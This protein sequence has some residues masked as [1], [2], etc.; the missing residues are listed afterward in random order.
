M[1]ASIAAF[2][3]AGPLVVRFQL[4]VALQS[5]AAVPIPG[6]RVFPARGKNS[7]VDV[8]WH[9]VPAFCAWCRENGVGAT[10]TAWPA[11]WPDPAMRVPWESIAETLEAR[12]EL[13]APF[14]RPWA[15]GYQ[16][17]AL[18]F[19]AN[20]PGAFL[21]HP[22]GSGK[23]WTAIAWALLSGGPL[24]VVTPA[25]TR[26]QYAAQIERFTTRKAFAC[27]PATEIRKRDKW[28]TLPEYLAWCVEKRQEPALV[29]GWETLVDWASALE[30]VLQ[31][32]DSALIFDESQ[33]GKGTKRWEKVTLP[34]RDA[35]NYQEV[36]SDLVRR[37]ANFKPYDEFEGEIALVP[38]E[39]TVES[40][41]RLSKAA[42]RRLATTATPV[43]NR[44]PDL[45]GQLDLI[46]PWAWGTFGT[47]AHRYCDAKPGEYGGL[48]TRGL[49]NCDELRERLAYVMHHVPVAVARASLPAKRRQVWYIS[50]E[51]QVQPTGGWQKIIKAAEGRGGTTL[52]EVRLSMAASAKRKA[53]V[54]QIAEHVRNGDKSVVFTARV[55]DC[56]EL[57]EAVSKIQEGLTVFC[58]HGDHSQEE[59]HA[60]LA[61]YVEHPGP[62]ILVGTGEAW[63]TGIDGLQCTDA[64]FFA[65]LPYTIG[66][67]DQQEGRF[68]R[69]GQRGPV[70]IYYPIAEGTA[71][72]H[73]AD[74]LLDKLDG[75][76]SVVKADGVEGVRDVLSGEEKDPDKFAARVLAALAKAKDQEGP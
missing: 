18:Q 73:L 68:T 40:A 41:A 48:D 25:A 44:R 50:R 24:V 51:D 20:R 52:L 36:R 45:W 39:N 13:R 43:F 33:R 8:T 60:M 64:V 47:F 30:D 4:A 32:R 31:P 46:E 7:L 17:D 63:G 72:E 55:R 66:Q 23:T 38:R 35:P 71:D 10:P 29:V 14:L 74:I 53:L 58:G 1:V 75:V 57:A 67:L 54:G 3:P 62:C 49:S 37:G 9:A 56:E 70:L 61:R 22:T 59:R 6:V 16:R 2:L 76:E 42:A 12:G 15:L 34:Q 11:V 69:H 27:K 65:M 28:K 26:L 5:G 19:A 21:H